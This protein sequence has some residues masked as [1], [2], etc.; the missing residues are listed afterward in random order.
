MQRGQRDGGRLRQDDN[1]GNGSLN[2]MIRMNKETGRAK[3][4]RV[5]RFELLRLLQRKRKIITA[6]FGEI[7]P[8]RQTG[9]EISR[10]DERCENQ[11]RG[12]LSTFQH[13]QQFVKIM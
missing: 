2:A 5:I 1:E 12:F 3:L 6:L 10:E 7:M 11:R 4:W 9:A 13:F 8:M